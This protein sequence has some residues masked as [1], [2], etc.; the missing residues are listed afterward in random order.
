MKKL[1]FILIG[2]KG[3]G[4]TYIGNRIEHLTGIKFLRVEP[5]WLQLAEG[6]NGWQKVETEIDRLFLWHDKV[7]IESLGAGDGFNGMYASLKSKYDV[8][9]IKVDTDL[10]ECLRRVQSRDNADHIPVSDE[11]VQEYNRIAASINH[12]WDAVIDN[13]DPATDQALLKAIASVEG[14]V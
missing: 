13:N 1:L 11:K 7:I 14:F 6:E 5:L 2:P 10:D 8:K 4:K 12:P 3:S 9:L